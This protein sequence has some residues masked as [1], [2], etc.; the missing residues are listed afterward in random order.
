[1]RIFTGYRPLSTALLLL[2]L[3]TACGPRH[4]H[5]ENTR[6]AG[7]SDQ[8]PIDDPNV[9]TL[10]T[11]IKEAEPFT[12]ISALGKIKGGSACLYSIIQEGNYLPF[13]VASRELAE[14][15]NPEVEPIIH[16]M[17][18]DSN[19]SWEKALGLILLGSRVA[20]GQT[21]A[22]RAIPLVE[23]FLTAQDQLVRF[24]ATIS[25]MRMK[26][27]RATRR[28]L[29]IAAEQQGT[30]TSRMTRNLLVSA[31]ILPFSAITRDSFVAT[32]MLSF[33]DAGTNQTAFF[34]DPELLDAVADDFQQHTLPGYKVLD[35]GCSLGLS[36][37]SLRI[38]LT[39]TSKN[40]NF[41][42]VGTE[43]NP[44]ALIFATRGIYSLEAQSLLDAYRYPEMAEVEQLDDFARYAK[45][46]NWEPN[47]ILQNHFKQR[48]GSLF[49]TR[50]EAQ[51]KDNNI[52][53]VFD[54]IALPYST[55]PNNNFDAIVYANVHY[56]LRPEEGNHAIKRIYQHLTPGGKVFLV[57]VRDETY[58][59]FEAVFGPPREISSSLKIYTKRQ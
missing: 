41:H 37:E 55:L 40:T 58:Q 10:L 43:I 6:V 11:Q 16:K 56:L 52:D 44:F 18:T 1:M 50:Y 13:Y 7:P 22:T 3:A 17:I 57:D 5:I 39:Q 49:G 14:S 27:T 33:P 53:F 30:P 54:N 2:G 29:A 25:L 24:G 35:V 31:R 9:R 34:R 19:L 48:R 20:S 36:T 46:H 38:I 26:N 21:K 47:Q 12:P 8:C 51:R 28:L 32:I 45:I 23:P 42:L 4:N 59:Q 15:T